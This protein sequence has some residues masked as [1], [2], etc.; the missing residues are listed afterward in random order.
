MRQHSCPL[1]R[2]VSPL[3]L[4]IPEPP[5]TTESTTVS[6]TSS[7]PVTPGVTGSIPVTPTIDVLATSSIPTEPTI[8]VTPTTSSIP[9]T[10]TTSSIPVTPTTSSI[11][12]TPTIDVSASSP[13]ESPQM[14]FVTEADIIDR[15]VSEEVQTSSSTTTLSVHPTFQRVDSVDDSVKDHPGFLFLTRN[16]FY[17]FIKVN[18]EQ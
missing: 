6:A 7:I 2:R 15:S 11:P 8:P 1:N 12:V 16:D 14:I 18:Y 17:K 10:P 9:V 13:L 5:A 4:N 3:E